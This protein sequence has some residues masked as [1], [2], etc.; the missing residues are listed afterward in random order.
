EARI[1]HVL[2]G[3]PAARAGLAANDLLLALDGLRLSAGTLGP[4]L[5]AMTP[6]RDIALHYFRGDELCNVKLALAAPPKDTWALTLAASPNTAVL[7]RRKAWL[8]A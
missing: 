6:G 7:A 3:S 8:G 2:A 4:R 5:A 1:A